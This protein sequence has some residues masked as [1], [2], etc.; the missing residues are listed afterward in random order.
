MPEHLILRYDNFTSVTSPLDPLEDVTTWIAGLNSAEYVSDLLATVHNVR[1]ASQIRQ[2]T[3]AV[4]LFA[5]SALGLLEQA[6][7]GATEYSF[8][9]LYYAI[10]NLSK[11]YLVANH[12]LDDLAKN[13][14]HGA[15]YNPQSKASHD[16][17]TEQISLKV[18]GV[19]PM[20]YET[21]TGSRWTHNKKTLQIKEFI[22]YLRG[23]SFEYSRAY[24]EE[25]PF[26]FGRIMVEGQTGEPGF[27]LTATLTPSP[28]PNAN[29][30]RHLKS[31]TGLRADPNAPNTF[32][33]QFVV[34]DSIE[35]AMQKLTPGIRRFLLYESRIN[36]L[37]R[38][39]Q[40]AI[41]PISNRQLLMVE[42]IPIWLTF[43]YLSNIVRYN[44]E[45]ID[46]LKDSKAWPILLALS[47][48]CVLRFLILFWSYMHNTEFYISP[49]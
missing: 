42:E 45:F 20:F 36:F 33:S 44:P 16:L 41:M 14:W 19:F 12:R 1:G 9:P 17:L 6:Y 29:S 48:H 10:L 24:K 22:P 43:F 39:P 8:L 11:I 4:S 34:A 28:H 46:K 3:K 37:S 2:A 47:K 23:A 27:R 31:I 13:K 7:S 30:I 32:R 18:A 21:L 15:T 38:S 25:S 49:L 5:R 40:G 35:D 26:Q